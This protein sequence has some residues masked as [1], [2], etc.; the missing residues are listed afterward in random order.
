M[1]NTTTI[2]FKSHKLTYTQSDMFQRLLTIVDDHNLNEIKLSVNAFRQLH[3]PSFGGQNDEILP[4]FSKKELSQSIILN[5]LSHVRGF[6]NFHA[7]VS[8]LLK[9]ETN[10]PWEKT[11]YSDG[12]LVYSQDK[13][14][15]GYLFLIEYSRLLKMLVDDKLQKR[16]ILFIDADDYISSFVLNYIKNRVPFIE[17]D[18]KISNEY[19]TF[20]LDQP[21]VSVFTNKSSI[22]LAN[23]RRIIEDIHLGRNNVAETYI[24][25]LN[26]NGSLSYDALYDLHKKLPGAPHN[27]ALFTNK[28]KYLNLQKEKSDIS[29]I[30]NNQYFYSEENTV[31]FKPKDFFAKTIESF[32]LS[33]DHHAESLHFENNERN[34]KFSIH[35]DWVENTFL[36]LINTNNIKTEFEI[37]KLTDNDI[38]ICKDM[39]ERKYKPNQITEYCSH[40]K[41]VMYLYEMIIG[42]DSIHDSNPELEVADDIVNHIIDH[43]SVLSSFNID[44]DTKV[45]F[46]FNDR[47]NPSLK[48]Q[49][50][51]KDVDIQDDLI[52]MVFKSAYEILNKY[53]DASNQRVSN[54][55]EFLEGIKKLQ[56]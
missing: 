1:K 52:Q 31:P 2:L 18:L 46:D 50:N 19:K 4:P 33:D 54:I 20:N 55:V 21:S 24:L 26:T 40:A 7:M 42:L 53:N 12:K 22:G 15:L 37:E 27:I 28:L 29:E 51:E 16:L 11:K 30:F 17:S 5:E 8:S 25:M 35:Y 49:K 47:D 32:L 36:I 41:D 3:S 34:E 14:L 6:K 9:N 44:G 10:L 39:F 23:E 13:L 43:A 45:V 56:K 38:K 48:F